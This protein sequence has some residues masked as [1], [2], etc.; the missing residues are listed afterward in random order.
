MKQEKLSAVAGAKTAAGALFV[1]ALLAAPRPAP[2]ADWPMF[3]GNA[4]RTGYTAEQ[5]A[6]PLT[7]VWDYQLPGGAVSSPAIYDGK[8][9]IGSRANR[10]YALDARTGALLWSRLT[11]GWVDSSPYVSST[12]VY[13]ACLG[14][15]LYAVDRLSGSLRWIVDLGAA[16]ASSPLVLDGRVY[17][18]TGSP[19]NK[20]KVYDAGT[21]ALLA[22]F[23]AGQ[24]VDSAPST[25]GSYIYFGAN[26]GK[27]YALGALTLAARWTPYPTLGSFGPN[28]VAVSSGALYFLP[29]RDEKSA[30]AFDAAAGTLLAASPALTRAGALPGYDS[31]PW[32]QAGSPAVDADGTVYFTAAGVSAA[33]ED[34]TG[35]LAALSSGS[36]SAVWPSSA[37]LGGGS[38]IGMLA[39]P[40]AANEVVYA[41]TP[42]GRLIAVSSSGAPLADLD[43]SGPA[44]AS[45]AVADGMI[46]AV[47]YAGK[48]FGFRAGRHAAITSPR[49][50]EVL[51]GTVAVRGW[52]DSPDLAGYELEYSTDGVVPQWVRIS[53]AAAGSAV[54][55]AVLADWD[56]SG[57]ENGEY[58]LRLRVLEA[59]ASGYDASS[60]VRVRI[61]AVPEPPSG[62]AAADVPADGGNNIALSWS[63]SPSAGVA[64]YRIY[65]DGG[66]GFSLIAST[67]TLAYVDSAA[68]TGSTY[69]YAATAW[70]GW[71]E[72]ARSD[73]A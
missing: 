18:G 47:N 59:P 31:V 42:A 12:T 71:L 3:R 17:I 8:V 23:Q 25:D 72:S 64:S 58:L 54:E 19:E 63:A 16:S 21:G 39:S 55:G 60:Q 26:N 35:H 43:L 62:L 52:F 36:L 33:S 45:P 24:P 29:G 67:P 57:L 27:V 65:R 5:A 28:A 22:A 49:A 37:S 70:D 68:L 10:L 11:A 48:I 69:A 15:R 34:I 1:L 4:A 14:G 44:Y 13:A 2:A 41:A 40:A 61:N 30:T 38:S 53:S 73:E 32:M 51:S 9:Y 56:V 66:A 7:Q 20:L 6:P 50:G 46:I